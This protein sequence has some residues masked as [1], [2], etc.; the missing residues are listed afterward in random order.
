VLPRLLKLNEM[1]YVK[2]KMTPNTWHPRQRH[3]VNML[4][5]ALLRVRVT[6]LLRVRH[7]YVCGVARG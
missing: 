5:A 2:G 7:C 3:C 4:M 1:E 6:A